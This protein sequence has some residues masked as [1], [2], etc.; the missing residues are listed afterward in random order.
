MTATKDTDPIASTIAVVQAAIRNYDVVKEEAKLG[1]TFH[2][3]G[4]ALPLIEEALQTARILLFTEI[5]QAA[6]ASLDSC[7]TGATLSEAVF[8]EVSQAPANARLQTYTTLIDRK[9]KSNLVESLVSGMMKNTCLFA[10]HC[11]LEASMQDQ[12]TVLRDAIEKLAGM[13]PSAAVEQN[14][15]SCS[16]SNFGTGTQ[17]NAAG[18]T[19]NNVTGNGKQFIGSTFQGT[20]TFG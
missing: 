3:A 15:A 19:Q 11:G 13:E 4:R 9:G 7:S 16:F 12:L 1:E 6:A 14:A 17:Y 18:G 5:S 8:K 10:K 20:V 2:E